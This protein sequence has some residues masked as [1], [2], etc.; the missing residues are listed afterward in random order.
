VNAVA[1][2]FEHF[3]PTTAN[4]FLFD[5]FCSVH[6]FAFREPAVGGSMVYNLISATDSFDYARIARLRELQ[7]TFEALARYDDPIVA[8]NPLLTELRASNWPRASQRFS[9]SFLREYQHA[10]PVDAKHLVS[11]FVET[12]PTAA[13]Q[14]VDL[15]TPHA[16]LLRKLYAAS[17]WRSWKKLALFLGTSH[18]QLGRIVS[19][20]LDVPPP[21]LATRI[22][23]LYGFVQRLERL[24]RGNKTAETR[25]LTTRRKRDGRS[26]LDFLAV[27]DYRSAFR[28]AMDAASSQSKI[29]TVEATTRQWYDEPSRDLYDHET[30]L[31][32]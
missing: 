27:Q 16:K 6:V 1:P 24:A 23:E 20:S 7:S 2:E 15:T 32:E 4:R 8:K 18:T 17:P 26:A 10:A 19:G 11:P 9:I 13:L 30:S 5:A 29:V 28:A 12:S 14:A 31:E 21:V 3:I 25:L 22:D